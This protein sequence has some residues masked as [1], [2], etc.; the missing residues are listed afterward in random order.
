M[1]D[2]PKLPDHW[3][4][5]TLSKLGYL[6]RG[7]SK[8]RPRNDPRL[9][10]KVVPFIQTGEVARSKGRI[11]NFSKMYSDFGVQQSRIFPKGTICIT[12][13]AN[14]AD[15]GILNFDFLL[16]TCATH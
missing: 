4:Y 15:S 13:A 6:A 14:I 12:I 5:V 11:R 8:H 2:F 1:N 10:G 9:F 16:F 7:K 3:C